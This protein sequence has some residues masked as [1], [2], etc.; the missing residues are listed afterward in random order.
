MR[1]LPF[2][3]HLWRQAALRLMLSKGFDATPSGYHV[4]Y[5]TAAQFTCEY[6][7]LF[8]APP[9]RDIKQQRE[10]ANEGAEF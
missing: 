4:G 6:K 3:K 9:L 1:P 2:Q 5:G 10:T 8:G 7:R